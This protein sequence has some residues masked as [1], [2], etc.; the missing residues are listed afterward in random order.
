MSRNSKKAI[1]AETAG[2]IVT[3]QGAQELTLDAVAKRANVSKG[4]VLYHFPTKDALVEGML[5]HL[6]GQC[7]EQVDLEM[8]AEAATGK[9]PAAGRWLRA[10]VKVCTEPPNAET[11][12]ARAIMGVA[13]SDIKFIAALD[14]MYD[15]WIERALRDG[16]SAEVA[17]LVCIAADGCWYYGLFSPQK[18]PAR[19]AKLRAT[20][21]NLIAKDLQSKP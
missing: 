13:L 5:E 20:L 7:D 9:F 16:I 21:L 18:S 19:L 14:E 10:Y 12:N 8:A 6:M 1:L 3:E 15:R 2:L 4:G 11:V 17:D